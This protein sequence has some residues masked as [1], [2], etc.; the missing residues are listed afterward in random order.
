VSERS[1][2]HKAARRPGRVARTVDILQNV[3]QMLTGIDEWVLL[4]IV[5][6]KQ[7]GYGVSIHDRLAEAGMQSSLGAIY[8]SLERLEHDGFVASRLGDA[9]PVRGGRR[10]RVFH[11]TSSGRKAL[12]ETQSARGRLLAPQTR[13]A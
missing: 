12:A 2:G 13:T 10:K 5:A 8:T 9:S 1:G 3:E 6:L 4:A 7:D 11:V